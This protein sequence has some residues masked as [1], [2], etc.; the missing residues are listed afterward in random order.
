MKLHQLVTITDSYP[1]S[2]PD[3]L[4]YWAC[5]KQLEIPQV[6]F[7]PQNAI[8]KYLLLIN[9]IQV[10]YNWIRHAQNVTNIP[11]NL[12]LITLLLLCANKQKKIGLF[13]IIRKIISARVKI[14][15][16][17]SNW[18]VTLWTSLVVQWVRTCLPLQGHGL[19]PWAGKVPHATEQLS[20]AAT[21]TEAGALEPR[22]TATAAHTPEGLCFATGAPTVRPT[23]RN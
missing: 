12:L 4:I 2:W 7:F 10:H 8:N 15:K 21:P 1:Q 9:S 20:L 16:G 23:H 19:D 13:G 14:W 5:K 3:W 11:F 17:F 6:F 22:A 18:K